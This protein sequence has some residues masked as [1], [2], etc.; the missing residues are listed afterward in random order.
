MKKLSKKGVLLFAAAMALCAFAMPSMASAATFGPA[1]SEHTLDG[2]NVGFINDANGVS[3]K[4]QRTQF[5]AHIPSGSGVLEITS[6][7]FI[8]CTIAGAAIGTCTTTATG[9]NFPW[10]ATA[11]TTSNI[12]IHGINIDVTF[13]NHPGS[14]AC[15]AAGLK[16]LFTGTLSGARWT[17]DPGPR[18]IDLPSGPG[19]A[20]G[21]FSHSILGNGQPVTLTGTIF[22]TQNTLTVG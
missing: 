8:N 3:S 7:S 19:G 21:L 11:T 6:T 22:D 14:S 12:Q 4:C 15:G 16:L 13:E 20:S 5:T 9:T 18:E 2:I 10:T 17:G 1:N